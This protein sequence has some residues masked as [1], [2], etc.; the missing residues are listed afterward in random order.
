MPGAGHT[1]DSG[2]QWTFLSSTHYALSAF[3]PNNAKWI[4]KAS[5]KKKKKDQQG[6]TAPRKTIPHSAKKEKESE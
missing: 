6:K 2:R 4:K 1:Q 3:L 5:E